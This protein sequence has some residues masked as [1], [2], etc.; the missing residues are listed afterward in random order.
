[1]WIASGR[2]VRNSTQPG[3]KLERHIS[4]CSQTTS[5]EAYAATGINFVI[6]ENF[7]ENFGSLGINAEE[8]IQP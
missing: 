7:I 5:K 4:E 3:S 8:P 6:L 2:F 1:M